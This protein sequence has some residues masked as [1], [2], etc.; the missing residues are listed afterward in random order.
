MRCSQCNHQN[1][2]TAKFCEECSARLIIV[3]PQ[4]G[5]QVNPNGKILYRMWDG[6][7]G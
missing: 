1:G 4:C 6:P 2:N 7:H 5:Q 3:C